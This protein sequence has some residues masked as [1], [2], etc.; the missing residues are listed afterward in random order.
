METN[1]EEAFLLFEKWRD[2]E[3]YIFCASSLFGWGITFRGRVG[4]L[5]RDE[6]SIAADDKFGGLFL[7]LQ[8]PDMGFTYVEP[9]EVP[10]EIMGTLPESAREQSC[11][12][13]SLP[14]RVFLSA[15]EGPLTTPRRE[16]LFFVE[17]ES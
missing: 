4:A 8:D 6:V 2:A 3:R 10:L 13:V 17:D 15:M 11:L 12:G 5:S 14:L 7:R 9:R 1:A 16:K